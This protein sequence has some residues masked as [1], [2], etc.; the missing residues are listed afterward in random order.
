[1]KIRALLPLVSLL[2]LSQQPLPLPLPDQEGAAA[3]PK[4]EPPAAAPASADIPKLPPVSAELVYVTCPVVTCPASRGDAIPPDRLRLSFNITPPADSGDVR[5]PG[6][7]DFE[8]CL[9]VRDASGT[10]AVTSAFISSAFFNSS[11]RRQDSTIPAEINVS[12]SPAPLGE[13]LHIEGEV[14]LTLCNGE[15]AC[16]PQSCLRSF[17]LNGITFRVRHEGDQLDVRLSPRDALRVKGVELLIPEGKSSRGGRGYN[18][19][20]T[21]YFFDVE[22]PLDDYRLAITLYTDIRTLPVRFDTRLRLPVELNDQESETRSAERNEPSPDSAASPAPAEI[23]KLPPVTAEPVSVGCFICREVGEWDMRSPVLKFQISPPVFN[24]ELAA[25]CTLAPLQQLK[26][27]GDDGERQL[28]RVQVSQEPDAAIA[29]LTLIYRSLTAG[30]QLDLR[31]EVPLFIRSGELVC[32]PQSCRSS[33]SLDGIDFRVS[34]QEG[35]LCVQVD[36]SDALR[37]KSFKL[38]SPQGETTSYDLP[39]PAD[40]SVIYSFDTP[41]SSDD[42]RLAVT[43]YTDLKIL[44]VRFDTRLRLPAALSHPTSDE[45]SQ[46][47]PLPRE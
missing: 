32:E 36:G 19:D 4:P 31:G 20:G 23:P 29:E 41:T 35:G 16:E 44:P 30:E 26:T 14:M 33:F 2:P 6:P 27:I 8:R 17:R 10:R 12:S 5:T 7:Q 45:A 18:A 25:P 9:Q 21:L 15:Q 43:L 37:I 11:V 47:P 40:D 13:L 42:D 46:E 22:P 1:M 38:L 3:A 34:R 24:G 39:N 28:A